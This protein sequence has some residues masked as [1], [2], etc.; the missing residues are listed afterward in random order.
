MKKE[1]KM[2]IDDY[3]KKVKKT[4]SYLPRD[5]LNTRIELIRVHILDAI[6]DQKND[7]S[8]VEIVN[9][10][11]QELGIPVKNTNIKN[12]LKDYIATF[13]IGM[14]FLIVDLLYLYPIFQYSISFP[15]FL[16]FITAE[17]G[18][19]LWNKFITPLVNDKR[20]NL[21]FGWVFFPVLAFEL[22]LINTLKLIPSLGLIN[23]LWIGLMVYG[24]VL[25]VLTVISIVAPGEFLE[26]N[27]PNCNQL[28]PADAKYCLKCGESLE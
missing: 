14:I 8:E 4:W 18:F 17:G 5:E 22:H 12:I 27:C 26:K 6:K 1:T 9:K 25:I 23:V 10:V 19:V 15:Y 3:I 13:I 7:L 20:I 11:I 24:I 16:I 21:L 2:L 28:L